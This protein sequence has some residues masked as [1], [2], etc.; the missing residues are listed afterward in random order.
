MTQV[1]I[2]TTLGLMDK[3]SGEPSKSRINSYLTDSPP[4]PEA[5][6]LYLACTKL[7]GFRFE[8]GEYQ[9]KAVRR[10]GTAPMTAEQIP[11]RFARQFDLSE[12]AG[13]VKVRVKRPAG[14]IEL[15]VSLDGKAA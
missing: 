4:M 7:R 11:F 3:K 12:N 5:L 15:F 8:Y 14:R 13:K 9:L 2:A 6:M 1:D 10:K